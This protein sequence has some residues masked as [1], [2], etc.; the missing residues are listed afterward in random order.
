M[1]G[2]ILEEVFPYPT[3]ERIPLLRFVSKTVL[4]MIYA[5]IIQRQH[6]LSSKCLFQCKIG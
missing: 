1:A 6:A 4:A 3:H 5:G 2:T